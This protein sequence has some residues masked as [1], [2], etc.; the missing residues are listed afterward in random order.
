M[1]KFIC[2]VGMACGSACTVGSTSSNAVNES[3]SETAA[4]GTPAGTEP[5]GQAIPV[6]PPE[7]NGLVVLPD[8]TNIVE[9]GGAVLARVDGVVEVRTSDPVLQDVTHVRSSVY[10]V[11]L[12][13]QARMGTH[14]VAWLALAHPFDAATADLAT[15]GGGIGVHH[16]GRDWFSFQGSVEV[17]QQ[18]GRIALA[19]SN[20]RFRSRNPD[21]SYETTEF[22]DGTASIVGEWVKSCHLPQSNTAES[23]VVHKAVSASTS[24]DAGPPPIPPA[25]PDITQQDASANPPPEEGI[26]L[27]PEW[28]AEF[29]ADAEYVKYAR[30]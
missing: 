2:L 3:A 1:M 29:C 12:S 18:E 19:F 4:G 11:N 14:Q 10:G 27:D 5:E 7:S 25:E 23:E 16:D 22:G 30:R 6:A 26:E 8:D 15:L 9:E 17:E 13:Y 21:L 24:P 20:L 28:V